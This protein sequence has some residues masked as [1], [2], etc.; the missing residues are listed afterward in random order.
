MHFFEH[1]FS[2]LALFGYE[3][4][5]AIKVNALNGGFKGAVLVTVGVKAFAT[6]EGVV[7]HL[8]DGVVASVEHHLIVTLKGF[9]HLVE[10]FVF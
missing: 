9:E 6:V 4:Q 10:H 5:C 2:F 1:V 8:A 7:I 3:R